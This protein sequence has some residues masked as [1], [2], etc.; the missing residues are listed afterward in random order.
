MKAHSTLGLALGAFLLVIAS[1]RA[2]GQI[3]I[4]LDEHGTP[5]PYPATIA[6]DPLNPGGPPT[7][8]YTLPFAVV[9]GDLVISEP[10]VPTTLTSDLL[11]FEQSV[12]GQQSLVFVYSDVTTSDP[13]NEPA[14]VGIPGQLQTNVA[15]VVETGLPVSPIYTDATN[16]VV[17]TP[18]AGMPGF[19][20]GAAPFTY[21]FISDVPE[22]TV[23]GLGAAL[24]GLAIRRPR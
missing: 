12:P 20:A 14:D 4:T 23:I 7:V 9:P 5:A 11:R 16:G 8:A 18:T 3:T 17:Y 15:M 22:P 6:I 24:V 13:A 1:G 10:P 2:S 21:S 19:I